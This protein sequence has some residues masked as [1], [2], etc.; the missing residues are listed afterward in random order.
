MYLLVGEPI[1]ECHRVDHDVDSDHAIG[2]DVGRDPL[3]STGSAL[4][5]SP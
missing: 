1:V 2:D 4:G 5:A 3:R